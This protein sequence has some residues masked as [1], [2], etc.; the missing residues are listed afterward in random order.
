MAT[1]SGNVEAAF[2]PVLQAVNTMREGNR[3][4]K[5]A[6]YEYLE[7]FQKSVSLF[8]CVYIVIAPLHLSLC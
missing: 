2:A 7:K 1:T 3:D 4:Q 6:A 5:K 8:R